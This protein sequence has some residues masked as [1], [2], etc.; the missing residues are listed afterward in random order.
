VTGPFA[1]STPRLQL[2]WLEP[3]DAAFIYRLVTDA[4][5][6]RNIGD[7]GVASLADARRY[8][9][10]GPVAM[11]R[12][13]GHGLNR[14]SLRKDDTPIGICGILKRDDLP[15]ADLGY[16]LLPE[17]RGRG[18][19]AEAAAAVLDHARGVLGISRVAAIVTPH[20]EASISLLRNL[21]FASRG[22]FTRDPGAP[23]VEL[24]QIDL[25]VSGISSQRR[26]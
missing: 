15:D 5:W 11:Y 13:L 8:I 2:R 14:V 17:F 21:G 19:A 23:P 24:Y 3:G 7:K 16:A 10:T 22:E 1:I 4:D 26:C 12:R 20:N 18:Y 25:A 9:E 6:L